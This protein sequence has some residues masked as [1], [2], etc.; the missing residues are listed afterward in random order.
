MIMALQ[1]CVDGV[2]CLKG[3]HDNLLNRD[4]EGEGAITKFVR[5]PGEGEIARAW[6][7]LRFGA[8]FVGR[9]AG[10]EQRLPLFAVYDNTG[11][12]LKFAASHS[13]PQ[14][15]Y[16]VR[17]IEQRSPEVVFGLTWCRNRGVHV[18]D[19]L[20]EVFG[21]RWMRARYFVSHTGSDEGIIHVERNNLVMVNKP[22][23]LVAALVRPG[24]REFDV[25]IVSSG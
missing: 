17:E 14:R 12:G 3:N 9:Y 22:K 19:L 21:S 20:R 5:W 13:E 18:P 1:E 4:G 7:L 8:A 25:H 6:T 23:H 2:H 15:A 24:I 11:E 16:T 10:W